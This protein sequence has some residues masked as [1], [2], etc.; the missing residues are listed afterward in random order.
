MFK[1]KK[2]F[3]NRILWNCLKSYFNRINH[4]FLIPVK[5]SFLNSRGSKF[6][7]LKNKLKNLSLWYKIKKNNIVVFKK[8]VI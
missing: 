2:S 1:N 7:D 3:K 5:Y 8:N 4:I 6:S